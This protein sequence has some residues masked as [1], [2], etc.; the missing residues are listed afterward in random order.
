MA[1]SMGNGLASSPSRCGRC[2]PE[3]RQATELARSPRQTQQR[4]HDKD[5]VLHRQIAHP[6]G[7]ESVEV[8]HAGTAE[9]AETSKRP[10]LPQVAGVEILTLVE[11]GLRHH[12]APRAAAAAS[13]PR[14][15]STRLV[16]IGTALA[17]PPPDRSTA[18]VRSTWH[19]A[20][21]FTWTAF[22]RAHA[23]ARGRARRG[24]RCPPLDGV[25]TGGG[26]CGQTRRRQRGHRSCTHSFVGVHASREGARTVFHD[27]AVVHIRFSVSISQL[28]Q[29]AGSRPA[30]RA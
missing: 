22:Q 11:R 21:E 5:R 13:L 23:A 24:P 14:K 25:G 4:C 1:V 27:K 16:A 18:R 15:T 28:T 30:A 7:R 29:T 10:G 3:P 12:V 17:H 19:H 20:G 8:L 6:V 9:V 2:T 26:S